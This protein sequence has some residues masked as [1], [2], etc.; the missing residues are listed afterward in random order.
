MISQHA[1]EKKE[2]NVV[3][4][5]QEFCPTYEERNL[6]HTKFQKVKVS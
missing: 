1:K 5:C 3:N 6:G 2:N 4:A